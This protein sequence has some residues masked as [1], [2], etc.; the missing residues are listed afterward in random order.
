MST[1]A[2]AAAEA[3]SP[4]SFSEIQQQQQHQPQPG[5]LQGIRFVIAGQLEGMSCDAAARLIREYGGSVQLAVN[6]HTMYLLHGSKL[7]DGR[8]IDCSPNYVAAQERGVQPI[9]V[10][11]LQ[12]M[13]A[14]LR[15]LP[16]ASNCAMRREK[17]KAQTVRDERH[18]CLCQLDWC[19]SS[20][21]FVEL[22]SAAEHAEQRLVSIAVELISFCKPI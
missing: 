5:T 17:S 11:E 15:E 20:G 10:A 2:G 7:I 3:A 16:Y 21:P 4:V 13:I 22:P 8:D 1:L 19:R 9:T 18:K 12:A 14:E 6:A